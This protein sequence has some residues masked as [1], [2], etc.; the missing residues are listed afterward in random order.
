VGHDAT[1]FDL[2]E[3]DR[4]LR[5]TRAVRRRLDLERPVDLAVVAE[6]LDLAVQAPTGGNLQ[7]WRWL[8]V[9]DPATKAAVAEVYRR[10]W[11]PYRDERL[12]EA[13]AAG[14]S[15][16]HPMARSSQH[17]ADVLDRVPVLVIPCLTWR[18][19]ERP[20]T[21]ETASMY[22]SI[23][24][25]VWSFAL[26]LRSRGLG[27][28]LTTM[29]LAHEEEVAEI[30]GIPDH[31]TQVALLPVAHTIGLD[32]KPAERRDLARIAYLDRW[33]QPLRHAAR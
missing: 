24:P 13:A 29:H 31:V 30:L 15:A 18:S 10:A 28:T 8:V 19:S 3:T 20:R 14:F 4:L 32:F 16:D 26:A 22:G 27:T 9:E 7:G 21:F 12:A 11:V 25:A 2:S 5:T 23:L 17:L 1:P 33:K 6:C